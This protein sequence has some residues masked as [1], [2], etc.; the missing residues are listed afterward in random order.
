MEIILSCCLS[1]RRCFKGSA[2]LK[3]LRLIVRCLHSFE[4]D[5]HALSLRCPST[6]HKPSLQQCELPSMVVASLDDEFISSEFSLFHSLIPF[7]R[8]AS[9]PNLP[10]RYLYCINEL[11]SSSSFSPSCCSYSFLSPWSASRSS[12]S[13]FLYFKIDF[14]LSSDSVEL[15]CHL[16]LLDS[17]LCYAAIHLLFAHPA[18]QRIEHTCKRHACPC[19]CRS[20]R[21]PAESSGHQHIVSLITN[22]RYR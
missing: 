3:A 18:I 20:T 11:A 10:S 13:S 16:L 14:L 21:P 17:K 1:V 4:T 2:S 5:H 8:V 19:S 9:I 7:L 6:P 15:I 22:M 12:R